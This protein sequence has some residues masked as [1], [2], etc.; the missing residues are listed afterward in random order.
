MKIAILGN[1]RMGHA[2][3]T[4]AAGL[5]HD[6]QLLSRAE[7]EDGGSLARTLEAVDVAVDF[8]H[9]SAT[10]TH[11]R[12]SADAAVPLVVGTTGWYD[13]LDEARR[14]VDTAGTGLVWGSNFSIG[15]NLLMRLARAAAEALDAF[16]EYDPYVAEHHHRAKRDHPSG[17][18]QRLAERIVAAM[19]RKTHI[20]AGH[21]DGA[22]APD[23]LHV[24]SVRAG[25]AFGHHVVGFDA[26]TEHLQLVHT[27]K[28]RQ[29][30]ARGAVYAA[31][32]VRSRT[33][34]HE[35]A[36]II[37]DMTR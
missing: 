36:D 23:A 13:A 3:E 20:V 17:T 31:E 25:A 10:L 2:V 15:A 28:G 12:A 34:T 33:G 24:S 19:S 29:G 16:A 21:P 14:I 4:E 26:D 32:W 7:C 30:F 11:I 5:G 37:Q 35:F 8:T 22:I 9:A 1:G 18:A 27:A 6:A